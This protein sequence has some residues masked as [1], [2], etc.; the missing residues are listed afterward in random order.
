MSEFTQYPN[1]ISHTHI[2]IHMYVCTYHRAHKRARARK[3]EKQ[4]KQ[5]KFNET[6]LSS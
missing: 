6:P 4:T 1:K 2:L 5:K 3:S